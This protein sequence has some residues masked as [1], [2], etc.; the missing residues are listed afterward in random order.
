MD[1]TTS[2]SE[3]LLIK[4]HSKCDAVMQWKIF[5]N[6]NNFLHDMWSLLVVSSFQNS[7]MLVLCF[8]S[9]FFATSLSS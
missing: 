1:A 6:V 9:P 2:L 5:Y 4:S 7:H 3:K 8:D